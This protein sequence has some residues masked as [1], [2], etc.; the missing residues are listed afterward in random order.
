MFRALFVLYAES[1]G[2][3]PL[4]HTGYE[5][6]AATTLAAEAANA[7]DGLDAHSTSLWGRF[8]VLVQALRTGDSGMRVP[9][10]NGDLFSADALPGAA[11][12]ERAKLT[13]PAFG[14]ALSALGRDPESGTGV[15]Y[16]ALEI[17][18]LGHTY[19]GLLSLRLSLAD[20]DLALYRSSSGA[21]ERYEPVHKNDDPAVRAGEL[22]WQTNSGGRKASGVYY[23]PELLVEHLVGRTVV[24]ALDEHLDQVKDL[25]VTD[26]AAAA[27]E[28][29]QFRI[30]DPACGS[31]HF[32]VTALHRMAERID[33]FLA[34]TPLPAVREELERLRA[35]TGASVGSRAEHAELLHR[36]VL[37]RCIYGVDA[38]P[39]GAE[40]ARLS[41]WLASFV[42]GLSLAYLGHNIQVGDS[43]VGVADPSVLTDGG[44]AGLWGETLGTAISK[45]SAAAQEILAIDDRTPDEYADSVAAGQ[46][47]STATKSVVRLFDAWTAGPLGVPK[48]RLTALSNPE[49]I[50]E[51]RDPVLRDVKPIIGRLR[52]LHW[53][54]AFPEVF[55]G[56]QP[57]FDA[58]IGNPPW[59]EVTVEE[60]AFYARQSPRLRGLSAAPRE[61]AL[62]ELKKAHPE[63]AEN[64]A[65]EQKRTA[66]LRKFLGPDGGYSG[67]AGDPDLYKFFCQRYRTLLRSG[68]HLGVVLPRSTFLAKGS[69]KFREWLF[70][71][72]RVD[73]LDFLVNTGRWAFDAEPRY[74]VALLTAT[75][76]SAEPD[77]QS[78]I[79]G[80][81]DSASAFRQQASTCGV[82]SR[83]EALGPSDEVPL[84]RSQAGEPVLRKMRE[85]GSLFPYGGGRWRCF[86][87]A[88]FHETQDKKLWQDATKGWGLWK[89]ESF[90]QH[91]PHGA[92]ARWCPPTDA[93][94]K[95]ATKARPGS[96][97]L[98]PADLSLAE[99]RE[100]QRAEVG[101]VRLAFRD[102]SR[103][104]DSRTV[105]ASLVPPETFLT[106]KAPYLTFVDGSHRERAVCAA[107]MNS[108]PFDWQA[109]RFVE[110]NINFFILE[111]LA[112]PPLNP[113]TFAEL[114]RLGGRLSCP[115][116]RFVEVAEACEVDVGPIDAN[117]RLV[118]RAR[119]DA[120]V[121]RAYG[122]GPADTDVLAGDFTLDAL[123]EKH[124]DQMRTELEKLCR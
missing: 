97:S 24:P 93:A 27:R 83:R 75:A 81:A 54:L 5:A 43:L 62:A 14:Q 115:D 13:N 56:E 18:H 112:L 46:R 124:R 60:L 64:F 67:S 30:L 85:H 45:G 84:L 42:A 117:E 101:K 118:M 109:R 34:E 95:K 10:Y 59:E 114:V 8:R 39:M 19:E 17:G 37:K 57:G 121:S 99:R 25:A 103:A 53:P 9:A 91:D 47:L 1:A 73:R 123:P 63:L 82:L 70:G 116:E 20:T 79:A 3:L 92:E 33:R 119:V 72:S 113:E 94:V 2:Y 68:G 71:S 98:L 77:H 106:N 11:L 78:E 28:L 104:D 120:L 15:D 58:V 89:G 88:E 16:S 4:D 35:A 100:A 102:V 86:P 12:L 51:G 31:A 110:T 41:C 66:E 50:L 36:L 107:I 96:D 26:P 32:L 105:R 65:A 29:F 21:E 61:R 122:L 87:V 6:N 48:A 38:S 90:D 52:P 111:L 69:R 44:S 22:F 74:T 49:A 23:T 40:V 108:V 80:V 7:A 76:T 55:S